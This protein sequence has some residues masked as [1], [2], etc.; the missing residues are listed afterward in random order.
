[1]FCVGRTVPEVKK[2]LRNEISNISES[3]RCSERDGVS[4]RQRR[5]DHHKVT[6]LFYCLII[7]LGVV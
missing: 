6:V 3:V 5:Q 7:D 2:M 4:T 1:M